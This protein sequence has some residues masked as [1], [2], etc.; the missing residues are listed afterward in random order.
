MKEILG[1]IYEVTIKNAVVKTKHSSVVL[2]CSPPAK[3]LI[4]IKISK[5]NMKYLSMPIEKNIIS[6]I[7]NLIDSPSTTFKP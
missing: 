4:D 5:E 3:S 6:R 1:A 7:I 2:K